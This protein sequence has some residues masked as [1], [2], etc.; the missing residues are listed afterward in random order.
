MLNDLLNCVDGERHTNDWTT[1]SDLVWAGFVGNSLQIGNPC[2]VPIFV[3]SSECAGNFGGDPMSDTSCSS[4]GI[5]ILN[6]D[7][8]FKAV[9]QGCERKNERV[10]A[11]QNQSDQNIIPNETAHQAARQ[12]RYRQP[13][14]PHR[15]ASTTYSCRNPLHLST[16]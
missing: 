14:Q 5:D 16:D 9:L 7:V 2:F 8:S 10:L 11:T 13:A 3:S 6:D 15:A 12:Q 4:L 1:I